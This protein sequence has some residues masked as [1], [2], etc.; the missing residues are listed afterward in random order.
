M[1]DYLETRKIINGQTV[2]YAN[3]SQK[4]KVEIRLKKR[5]KV[6]FHQVSVRT[7]TVAKANRIEIRII[8]HPPCSAERLFHVPE[9][10][11]MARWKKIV[12][13]SC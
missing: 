10:E 4:Q 7:R 3:L 2:L 13:K 12:D 9:L 11:E 6:L 1:I 8:P 5:K